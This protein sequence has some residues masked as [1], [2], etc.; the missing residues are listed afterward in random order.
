MQS[1]D[2]PCLQLKQCYLCK[3]HLPATTACFQSDKSK[4]D[5]FT[6]R[7]K[8][9]QSKPKPIRRADL[10]C[11]ECGKT[12]SRKASAAK[13]DKAYYCSRSC[14]S[15]G[16]KKYYSGEN[17]YRYSST[18]VECAQC[19]KALSRKATLSAR[20]QHHFCSRPCWGKWKTKNTAGENSPHYKRIPTKCRQCGKEFSVIPRA[21]NE[22]GNFC[23][24]ECYG[25]WS[26]QNKTGKNNPLWKGGH[27]PYYGPNWYGQRAKARERDNYACQH[28]G[29]TETELGRQ[30]DVHHK[31]PIRLFGID[32]Y[33]DANRLSNLVCLCNRYHRVA[34]KDSE[35]LTQ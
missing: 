13:E 6:S 19:G 9:C 15:A 4:K 26:A 22:H 11:A 23:D 33:E 27:L 20:R 5:G 2:T 34:E 21:F 29:V 16:Y 14:A 12:F 7:C 17:C 10:G 31:I 30:L 24:H 1:H 18:D 8:S 35:S 25:L 32:R 28:C 3:E